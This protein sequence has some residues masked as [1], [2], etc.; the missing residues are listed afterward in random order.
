MKIITCG[1]VLLLSFAILSFSLPNIA[2]AQ[3][4]QPPLS[5]STDFPGYAENSEIIITG[6]VKT[7]SLA[8]YDQP[9]TLMLVSPAGNIVTIQQLNLDSNNEFLS[10]MTAGGPL[11]KSGGEYTIK[12]NYGFQKA[13]TVFNVLDKNN[14]SSLLQMKPITGRKH[15]LRKQ[16]FMI[17]H[18]ILGDRKYNSQID[19][20]SLN[21]NLM[22]H[23]YEIKFMINEK[24]YTFRA[25]LP[26]YFKKM[27]KAK[28]L[29]F[30]Y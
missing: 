16:L 7:S 17:G 1:A 2:N 9:V 10:T 27:L 22:L 6:K 5:I 3:S 12:A 23:S 14:N 18:S 28:R 29:T 11:W 25:S 13:E 8:D 19:K 24:K 20:K 21:K 4:D 26:D 15:Q 30:Q